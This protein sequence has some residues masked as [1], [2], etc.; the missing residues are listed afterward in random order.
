MTGDW[1]GVLDFLVGAPLRIALIVV[2]AAIVNRIGRRAVRRGLKKLGHGG[3]RE[4]LTPGRGRPLLADTEEITPR[5]AERVEALSTVLRS[6]DTFSK[7]R[8]AFGAAPMCPEKIRR[9]KQTALKV[10]KSASAFQ[11]GPSRQ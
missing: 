1:Q 11:S 3:L 6:V 2:G 9:P 8:W 10:M 4:R 5:S 7:F